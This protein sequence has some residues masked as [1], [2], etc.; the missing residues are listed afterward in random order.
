MS[1]KSK[2]KRTSSK[3][4]PYDMGNIHNWYSEQFRAKLAEWN[5]IAPASYSKNELKSLYMANL[6][7]RS[8][9]NIN[10]QGDAAVAASGES[11]P[12][13]IQNQT[14]S[15]SLLPVAPPP[16][17]DSLQTSVMVNMNTPVSSSSKEP[18]RQQTHSVSVLPMAQ[19]STSDTLQTN[20]M[21]NMMN[22]MTSLMKQVLDKKEKEDRCRQTLEQYSKDRSPGNDTLSIDNTSNSF[23]LHP[24]LI[25]TID[26]VSESLREKIVSGKYV[27]LVLLLIP[28]FEQTNEKKDR[29]RDAR[30]NRSLSIEEFIVAFNKYKRI[31]CTRHPWRKAELDE[32]EANIIDISRVYGRKFYEYHKIFSQ[33]CAVALEQ[34]KKVNWGEKDKDLMQMIIGGTQCNSCNICK[35]VSHTTQFCPQNFSQF[36]VYSIRTH[37]HSYRPLT[38][39]RLCRGNQLY[40]IFSTVLAVRKTNVIICTYARPAILY[41]TA[42]D[43]VPRSKF[44]L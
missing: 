4:Q 39:R 27:N 28:E 43:N 12:I 29:Y 8:D 31:H 14:N 3:S 20:V 6:S 16:A 10:S 22:T 2:R 30:L 25:K 38:A 42:R 5:I 24:E 13:V 26:Y 44:L 33:K 18:Q 11:A 35:E 1:S 23:G 21:V 7:H 34:G 37:L 32:Y 40:A 19:L 17:Q 15:A 36:G 41:L 9:P